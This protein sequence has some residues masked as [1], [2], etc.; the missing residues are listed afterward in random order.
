MHKSYHQTLM[1]QKSI[2]TLYKTFTN[3]L[4]V[5]FKQNFLQNSD[6]YKVASNLKEVKLALTSTVR[7]YTCSWHNQLQNSYIC[8][9]L[10]CM[11]SLHKLRL[12]HSIVNWIWRHTNLMYYYYYLPKTDTQYIQ[13]SQYFNCS[14]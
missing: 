5:T 12:E 9:Y 14:Y 10:S 7:L 1:L 2:M 4:K 6:F 8:I 13:I 11:S 3:V